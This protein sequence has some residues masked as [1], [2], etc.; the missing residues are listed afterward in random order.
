MCWFARKTKAWQ[1]RAGWISTGGAEAGSG[2]GILPGVRGY[3]ARNT[4][5]TAA[6]M[7]SVLV[8]QKRE[9]CGTGAGSK[10]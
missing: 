4:A 3:R 7:K 6:G 10:A 2:A 8:A 9:R 5:A 1:A